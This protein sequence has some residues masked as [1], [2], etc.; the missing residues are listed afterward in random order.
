MIRIS[1]VTTG[2]EYTALL[3][4]VYSIQV[5]SSNAVLLSAPC[6]GQYQK[7]HQVC[8]GDKRIKILL[9]PVQTF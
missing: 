8:I 3:F 4:K 1:P 7:H 5:Y 9:L 6:E 2:N